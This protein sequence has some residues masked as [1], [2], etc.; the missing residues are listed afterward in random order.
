MKEEIQK[1]LKGEVED[2]EETLLKYS[3]DASIF[4]IRPKVVVFPKDSLD[5]QNLVKWASV[6]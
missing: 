1:F 3:H 6:S 2:S 5:V 4:N